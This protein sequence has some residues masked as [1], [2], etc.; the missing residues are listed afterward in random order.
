MI[1]LELHHHLFDLPVGDEADHG[2]MIFHQ[3][4]RVIVVVV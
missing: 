3:A 4:H 1:V 2:V